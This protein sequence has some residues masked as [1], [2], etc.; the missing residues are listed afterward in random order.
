MVA[1]VGRGLLGVVGLP[2]SGA[3]G[4]VGAVTNGLASSTGL[5]PARA[6]RRPGRMQ[7]MQIS[8]SVSHSSAAGGQCTYGFSDAEL[9]CTSSSFCASLP[10]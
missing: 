3:L 2:L 10:A 5:S 4:L 1:G 6:V 8:C 9:L 7:G